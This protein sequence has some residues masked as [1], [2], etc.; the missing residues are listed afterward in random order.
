MPKTN[1]EKINAANSTQY[2]T[3]ARIGVVVV[4]TLEQGGGIYPQAKSITRPHNLLQFACFR[5]TFDQYELG[6]D[7]AKEWGLSSLN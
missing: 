4:V 2:N 6:L 5:I 7:L 1:I 3:Q